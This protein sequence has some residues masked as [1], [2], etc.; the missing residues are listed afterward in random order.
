MSDASDEKTVV[1]AC[2]TIRD[3]LRKAACETDCRHPFIWVES[4]LHLVPESLRRRLQEELDRIAGVDRVLLAFGFCGNAVA[5][6][7][8]GSY[9]LILPKV[10][11]CI[12]LL[13]GSKECREQCFRQGGVYF[14]TKGWLEG[15]ANIWTEYQSVLARFGPDRTERIYRRML[16]HYRTLGLIDTGAYDLTEL[17]PNVRDIAQTLKLEPKVIPGTVDYLKG[18]LSGPW[19]KSDYVVIPP[20]TTVELSHLGFDSLARVAA[21]QGVM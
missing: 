14:L 11:D 3:E 9:E 15:E 18:L 10:D 5:G 19:N 17:L 8:S 16:A 13:L 12:T 7:T 1:L 4:G 21:V 6:L 2:N 20:F